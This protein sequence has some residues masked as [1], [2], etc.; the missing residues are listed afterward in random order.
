MDVIG[1]T[2]DVNAEAD[3][4]LLLKGAE[5]V[6]GSPGTSAIMTRWVGGSELRAWAVLFSP[7]FGKQARS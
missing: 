3:T 2:G 4:Q 5:K 6:A 1:T 7:H